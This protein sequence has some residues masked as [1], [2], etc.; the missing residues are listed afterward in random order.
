MENNSNNQE[1][2]DDY[3]LLK[4]NSEKMNSV[5][6]QFGNKLVVASTSLGLRLYHTK[7]FKCIYFA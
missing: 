4:A 6:F 1:K 2:A 5:K 3:V 7:D